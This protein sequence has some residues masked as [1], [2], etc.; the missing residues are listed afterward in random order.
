MNITVEKK[1]ECLATVNVEVPADKVTSERNAILGGYVRE[2]K[3]PGFRS[4][5]A[6]LKV[7]EKRF[8]KKIQD[9]L[10]STLINAGCENAIRQ[11]DL[12][13]ISMSLSADPVLSDEG[14]FS[15]VADIILVPEFET[16]EYLGLEITA[17]SEET[18]DE[19]VNT[20]L[21]E[22]QQKMAEYNDVE[23]ELKDGDFAVIDFTATTDGKPVAEAIGKSA[24]F[25]D[26][27]E[28]HWVKI[29][30]EAVLPGFGSGLK[31][32]KVGDN[33]VLTLTIN[34]DFPLSEVRGA[35]IV[36]DITVKEVKEQALPELDDEFVDKLLPGKGMDDVKKIIHDQLSGEKKRLAS[37]IKVNQIVEILNASVEFDIP[38]ILLEQEAYGLANN[39]ID[40]G[41]RQGVSTH[42][43]E[44]QRDQIMESAKNQ[45][46]LN[47]K[48]NFILQAIAVKESIQ[49][50][51][52]ELVQRVIA[53]SKQ[54]KKPVQKYIKELQ[55]ANAIPNIRNS[56]L[57]GKS[58]DFVV[59]KANVTES[60]TTQ[61][62]ETDAE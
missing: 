58:I 46:K 22:L 3:I 16:P 39:T 2:A 49:V 60:T 20:A 8:E 48:T 28:N 18:T 59:S 17:P 9:Q 10:Y 31:G 33:K 27:R 52:Q 6:P 38:Q 24:G 61:S 26:G 53:M 25:L 51:E 40:R 29:Q 4:G 56:V 57:I 19:E 36:F 15:F 30:D 37:E 35:D 42:Q 11:E 47:L 41:L 23:R 45:A 5:K 14:A 43:L 21:A 7:I 32:L 34:E 55:K 50:S 54:V 44:E 13:V 12:K 62:I 1:P